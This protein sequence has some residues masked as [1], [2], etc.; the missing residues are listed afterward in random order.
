MQTLSKK[1][2]RTLSAEEACRLQ[3]VRDVINE[4]DRLT[5]K[6]DIRMRQLDK[7]EAELIQLRAEIEALPDL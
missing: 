5:L 1:I 3:E 7:I 2:D 4:I 6:D